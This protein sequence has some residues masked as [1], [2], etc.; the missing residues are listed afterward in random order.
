MKLFPN[1]TNIPCGFQVLISWGTKYVFNRRFLTCLS[2]IYRINQEL[3]SLKRL[4]YLAQ[5]QNFRQNAQK[6]LLDMLFRVLRFS[7]AS[8]NALTS[9]FKTLALRRTGGWLPC[10]QCCLFTCE[11][12][13]CVKS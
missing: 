13:V 12:K 9:S 7:K 2:W 1:F 11:T 4:E 6:I 10:G 3:H 8:F 5:V